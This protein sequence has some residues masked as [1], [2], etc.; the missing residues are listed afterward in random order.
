MNGF[1]AKAF[2]A[3]NSLVGGAV[4]FVGLTIASLTIALSIGMEFDSF[5][6]IFEQNGLPPLIST[7]LGTTMGLLIAIVTII[8]ASLLCGLFALL[9]E[10]ERHLREIKEL[11]LKMMKKQS[12][13]LSDINDNIR[14]ARGEL[15]EWLYYEEE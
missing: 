7:M 4:L 15:N 5:K 9:A 6:N 10:T 1:L 2:S 8:F 12:E 13:F 3:L 14:E 11:N